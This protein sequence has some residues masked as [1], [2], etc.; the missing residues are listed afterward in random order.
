M[1]FTDLSDELKELIYEIVF[2]TQ[3]PKTKANLSR[4]SKKMYS[5]ERM[6]A[7]KK[8]QDLLNNA[9]LDTVTKTD[10]GDDPET[11][12]LVEQYLDLGAD[13]GYYNNA[14]F[15]LA[16]EK[17]NLPLVKFLIKKGIDVNKYFLYRNKLHTT[18]LIEAIDTEEPNIKII[19]LLLENGAD[20]NAGNIPNQTTP[21]HFA[22]EYMTG[23]DD[24][25]FAEIVELLLSYGAD[26]N[27][28]DFSGRTPLRM[29]IK[30]DPKSNIV[31]MMKNIKL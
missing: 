31:K 3:S 11:V 30:Q 26:P 9:L 29:A 20:P 25:I 7:Y 15:K 10:I 1:D 17:Q 28:K 8:E 6:S 14:I 5:A 13:L 22:T 21:L 2:T 19:K 27:I 16:I 4:T 24:D 18:P 12:K 23:E